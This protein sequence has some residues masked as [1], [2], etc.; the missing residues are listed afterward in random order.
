VYTHGLPTP[1]IL[2]YYRLQTLTAM[3]S[4]ATKGLQTF[5]GKQPGKGAT[6]QPKSFHGN[7]QRNRKTAYNVIGH[8]HAAPQIHSPHLAAAPSVRPSKAFF[9]SRPPSLR[10]ALSS[11][12]GQ[13]NRRDPARRADQG[14]KLPGL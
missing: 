3:H 5:L 9:P 8:P 12:Q 11:D 4:I 10:L 14:Q 6:D 2:V 1:S 7:D 13:R